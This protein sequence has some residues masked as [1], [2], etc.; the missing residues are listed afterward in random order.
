ML[1]LLDEH[2]NPEVA[3]QLRGK[4]YDVIATEEARMKE[5]TDEQLLAFAASGKRV[6]VTYNVRD[7]QMLLW[8][9]HRATRHH[10]GII[11]VSEK[12]IPQRTVG[13]L[14]RA[15][16]KLLDNAPRRV[17]WLDDS[18]LFLTRSGK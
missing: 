17:D 1:L 15:L 4:G 6:L 3:R 5:A 16:K 18:A 8:E 10:S 9:W 11:F 2:I 12:T 13:R 14:V 7:F